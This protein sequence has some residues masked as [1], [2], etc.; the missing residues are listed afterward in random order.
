MREENTYFD[1]KDK[2]ENVIS[3]R[4]TTSDSMNRKVS[5]RKLSEK[6]ALEAKVELKRVKLIVFNFQTTKTLRDILR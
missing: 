5:V 4:K 1:T 6:T 3:S 2:D